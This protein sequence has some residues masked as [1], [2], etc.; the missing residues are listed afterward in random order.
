MRVLIVSKALVVSTY[1]KKLDELVKL[2]LEVVAVV[3]PLWREGKHDICF[4]P[5][6]DRGYE[7]VVTPLR[8]NGHFHL[9]WYPRLPR[10]LERFR[11][12]V[13][14]LDEEPY[15]LAT[16]LGMR[17]AARLRIPALFFSWQNINRRYPPPFSTME[18]A[19]Y[20]WAAGA[21][22][23]SNDAASILR[24]K[25]FEKPISVV[26]QFGVDTSLFV[27]S[28]RESGPFTVGFLNRLIPGKAPLIA[29]QAFAALPHDAQLRIVGD[30]PALPA[31]EAAVRAGGLEHRVRIER[32]VPS[33]EIPQLLQRLDAVIL[34]SVTTSRWKEQFGRVLIEAMAAGVPVV[35]SDSG[36]IPHVIGDAGLVVPEG[37][38]GALS[39]ALRQLYDCTE[40]RSELARRGRRRAVELYDNG[41]VAAQTLRA[42]EL[43]AT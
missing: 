25:G 12:D 23:G 24:D 7:L 2:G 9:H 41:C 16:F 38:A 32:R 29:L 11:P 14:H 10:L 30:G 21:L 5:G 17:S 13:V 4:E 31:I 42:Y 40:L 26:P 8:W 34:P 37:D 33:A 22:A 43:A 19:V 28:E 1:R 36:E 6:I 20:R 3:P 18:R 35:G 15:N 27:P 39:K